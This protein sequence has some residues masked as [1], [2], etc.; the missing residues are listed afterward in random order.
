[1][2][3]TQGYFILGEVRKQRVGSWGGSY[4]DGDG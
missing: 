4:L 1:M 3:K 2:G